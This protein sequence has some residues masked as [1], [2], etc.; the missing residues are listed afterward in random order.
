MLYTA[1]NSSL[2]YLENLV[3][4]D[5]SLLPLHL[6]IMEIEITDPSLIYT[7]PDSNY[8][9]DWSKVGLI[10]NK[11]LGDQWMTEKK[12][13]GIRVRS[14]INTSEFNVLLNPLFPHYNT[15]V[16]VKSIKEIAFDDR[17][18]T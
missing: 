3:Y 4:V 7:F 14:A 1:E 2:A 17:L 10:K 11:I 16:I 5:K 6:Y 8:P 13:L 12:F 9:K 15:F 18:V